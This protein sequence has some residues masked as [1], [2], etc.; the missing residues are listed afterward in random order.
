T[1]E[2]SVGAVDVKL[3]SPGQL[4]CEGGLK[5]TTTSWLV[6]AAMLK[7]L[8]EKTEKGEE[9]KALP[10]SV[11]VPVFWT[12]KV[13]SA[14]PPTGTLPKSREAGLTVIAGFEDGVHRSA[15]PLPSVAVLKLY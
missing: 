15:V 11:S 3:A 4:A 5:R 13:R 7:V 6:P 12:V 10:V 2:D 9:V 8:P 1:P 14:Q